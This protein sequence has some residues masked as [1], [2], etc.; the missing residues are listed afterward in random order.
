MESEVSESPTELATFAAGCF[1]G[2]ESSLRRLPGVIDVVVGYA[3]GSKE[4]PTYEEV[5]SGRTGHAEA[6]QVTFD[7]SEVSYNQLLD[8]FWQLHDPTTLNR[9]GPDFGTQYRSAIFTHSEVQ[10]MEAKASM[11]S[12]QSEFRQPIVTQIEPAGTFWPAEEYHQ[13]YFEKKGIEGGCHV[14][15]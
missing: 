5:C 8:A 11:E 7:P 4:S 2:V 9:Q 10:S 6:A 15:L 14:R 12:A 1:W 3:G 13:R